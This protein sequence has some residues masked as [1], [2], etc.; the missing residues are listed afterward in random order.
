M[1][2]VLIIG[3]VLV[4][5][6]LIFQKANEN[7]SSVEPT[8]QEPEKTQKVETDKMEKSVEIPT[9]KQETKA[10]SKEAQKETSTLKQVSKEPASIPVKT[11]QETTETEEIV[12]PS[13]EKPA[14]YT[15]QSQVK[16]YLYEWG[17]D[18]SSDTVNAG[19]VEFVVV[20]N[21]Q[22]TH[23]FSVKGVQDFGKVLP[24]ETR[25]FITSLG[26]GNFDIYSP[27]SIDVENGM[28]ETLRVGE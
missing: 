1:K 16:V 7:K 20:N 6:W 17:I 11:V 2:R 13:I 23:H 21:G 27:R 24:G 9:E 8:A 18:V 14:H 25:V 3:I 22:F 12:Q 4:A 10:E 26:T 5:I 28:S 19:N 15:A